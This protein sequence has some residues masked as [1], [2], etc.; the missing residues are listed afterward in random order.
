LFYKEGKLMWLW[1]ILVRYSRNK[2]VNVLRWWG[3]GYYKHK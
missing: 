1:H 2:I 3:I